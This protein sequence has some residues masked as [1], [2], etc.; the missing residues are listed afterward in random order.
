MFERA[1]HRVP[2]VGDAGIQLFFNGPEA[3]TPDGVYYL[4]ETPEVNGLFVAAGFNSVGIQSGGGAGWVMADWILDGH[5]P[6]DLWQVDVRRT[7]AFQGDPPFLAERIPE[8]LGLLYAMHWPHREYESARGVK[9]SP[10]H[11]RLDENL[12]VFDLDRE[13]RVDGDGERALWAFRRHDV[14]RGDVDRDAVFDRDRLL[15]NAGHSGCVVSGGSRGPRAPGD[16]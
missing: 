11:S 6:M 13:V 7:H 2:S 14:V 8:S 4:G 1:V 3:F 12:A 9:L 10:I 16:R 15:S 5:A